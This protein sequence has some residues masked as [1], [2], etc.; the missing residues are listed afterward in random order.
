MRDKKIICFLLGQAAL[1]M[2]LA[3]LIPILHA[4]THDH[5]GIARFFAMLMAAAATI[6]GA[7]FGFA[8]GHR[9]RIEVIDSAAAMITVWFV[10]AFIGSMPFILTG[11]LD[12]ID[13]ILETVSDITSAG[14]DF[15]PSNAP[16]E[17]KLWQAALMWQ[18]SLVFVVILVTLL[19]EVSG[20]F[21]MELSLSQ[22]QVFSPMIGQMLISAR[23]IANVYSFLTLISIGLFKLAGLN[24]WDASIMAMRCLS[25]GGGELIGLG[26]LYVEYA[27]AFSMLIACGN[28]LL[29]FRLAYTFLPNLSDFRSTRRLGV[30]HFARS[31]RLF[32]IELGMLLK[33]NFIANL[34]IFFSNSEVKFLLSTIAIGTVLVSITLFNNDYFTDGNLSFRR[35]LFH[36]ISFVSTT[37]MTLGDISHAPDFD[38]FFLFLL[39]SIG[40]CMG[41]VTGGLKIIRVLVLFKIT[42]IEINRTIHP[43]MMPS[44]KVNGETVPMRVVGRILSFFFLCM[45]ALFVFS[46][47]LS[48]SGQPFST[49]VVMTLACLTNVGVMPGLCDASTFMQLP[50]VM[51]LFCA[52]IFVV[53]RMEIFAFLIF[54]SSIDI[55]RKQKYWR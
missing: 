21:G 35:S 25:T 41:S 3:F 26:N 7:L 33:K 55:Q 17:L 23:R 18:G 53:G 29:Y 34:K 50:A 46:V 52:L 22:G 37:G 54:L 40:G 15:L 39:V 45:F 24:G 4:L 44:I 20:C 13:A 5:F 10:M 28:F 30:R 47:I 12:P 1:A 31:I 38:R 2:T 36:I 14:V 49:G 27:A 43:N 51:K 8:H 9:R 48:L 42:A 19:P 6:S 16:Y 32:L 11:W